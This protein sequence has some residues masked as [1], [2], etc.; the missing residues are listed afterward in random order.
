MDDDSLLGVVTT[1]DVTMDDQISGLMGLGFPRLSTISR[2]LANGVCILDWVT[3]TIL[4]SFASS[5]LLSILCCY[6]HPVFPY[7]GTG[8]QIG[9]PSFWSQPA[10]E[11]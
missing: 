2:A 10:E 3:E 4:T 1:S 7:F 8:G 6:S 5:F 9:I 11:F